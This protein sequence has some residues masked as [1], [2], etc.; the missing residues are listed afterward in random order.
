MSGNGVLDFVMF[1]GAAVTAVLFIIALTRLFKLTWNIYT[2]IA[3]WVIRQASAYVT[4]LRNACSFVGLFGF[5]LLRGRLMVRASAYLKTMAQPE[6]TPELANRTASS[7]DTYAAKRL[8]PGALH[9]SKE[10]FNGS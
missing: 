9:H 6:S 7:I 5:F 8:L 2:T 4:R 1:L 10:D 3:R